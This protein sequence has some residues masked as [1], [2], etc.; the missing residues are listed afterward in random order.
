MVGVLYQVGPAGLGNMAVLM[1]AYTPLNYVMV[2]VKM[3]NKKR[4]FSFQTCLK[5]V[6]F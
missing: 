2:V 1:V 4:A 5:R 6:L 3:R